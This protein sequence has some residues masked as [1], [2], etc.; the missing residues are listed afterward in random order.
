MHNIASASCRQI[1]QRL[2]Q[3][4]AVHWTGQYSKRRHSHWIRLGFSFRRGRSLYDRQWI[5]GLFNKWR[6]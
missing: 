4:R 1:R 2:L 3:G 5:L 6:L